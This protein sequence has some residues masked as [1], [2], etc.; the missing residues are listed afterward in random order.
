MILAPVVLFT[1][2]RPIHTKKTLEALLKNDLA[3]KTKLYVFSDGPRNATE[4]LK[5]KE[6]REVIQSFKSQNKFLDFE[7]FESDLNKGL[8]SS[9]I[10]GVSKVFSTHEK[11]IVLEDDLLTS[12]DFLKFMNSTLDKYSNNN[13]IGCV[14]GYNPL[15]EVPVSYQNDIYFSTRTNS[16]GWGTWKNVWDNVD[17]QAKEYKSFKKSFKQRLL[18]NQTGFDRAKRLDMQMLKDAR[19]WSILFGFDNF[20]NNLYTVYATNSKIIHI[21]WDGSGTHVE[22]GIDKFNDTHKI[23]TYPL[24]FPE[25]IILDKNMIKL[26]RNLFGSGVIVRIKDFLVFIKNNIF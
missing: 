21:G 6:V 1:F 26:Q 5:V 23:S 24:V 4:A 16:L 22:Q 11:V 15:R 20:I 9:I 25:K 8:A 13:N 14:T 10:S 17:W 2:N 19:S 7:V 18:F 3:I 12:V